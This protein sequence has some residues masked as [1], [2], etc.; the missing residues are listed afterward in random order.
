MA[1][2]LI[3]YY[4]RKGQNYFS[5]AIKDIPKGNTEVIAE[6]IANETG[7]DLFEVETVKEYAKDYNECIDEAKKELKANSRPE[8]KK[9]LDNIDQYDNIVIAGPC[10]WGTYPC[11][12]FTLIEK[13][14]WEGKKVFPVMTH[15][16]SGMG[17]SVR[18][19]EKICKGAT[20]GESLAIYG[21]DVNNAKQR[22]IDWVKRNL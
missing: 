14:N 22:V 1:K 4:S 11:G 12:V 21:H 7:G 9:Y 5:G 6:Y 17:G 3:I 2:T 20:I 15:E 18:H 19:I 13:L 10:W 16:G 8:L